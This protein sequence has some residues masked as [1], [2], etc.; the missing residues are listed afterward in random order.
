[1]EVGMLT[2]VLGKV[3]ESKPGDCFQSKNWMAAG[4]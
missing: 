2:V 3:M 1:M 4:L